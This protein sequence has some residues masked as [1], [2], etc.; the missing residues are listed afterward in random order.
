MKELILQMLDLLQKTD[1][2]DAPG[3]I[4]VVEK[5]IPYLKIW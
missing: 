1:L 4:N 2:S 5:L 3:D